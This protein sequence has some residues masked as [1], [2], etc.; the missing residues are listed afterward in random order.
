M[1]SIAIAQTSPKLLDTEA[2]FASALEQIE[3]I[4]A[5]IYLFPE[6]FLSGYA[7]STE[8]EVRECALPQENRFFNEFRTLSEE[9]GI[10]ISGGYAEVAEGGAIYNSGF[11]IGNGRLLLNYRKTHLYYREQQFFRPGDSGFSVVEYRGVRFGMMICFD[12]FFPEAARSLAIRGAQVIL[13]PAN[14]VLPYCQRA[15]FARS[16]ENGVF[17]ATA[18]RVGRETNALGDDL[19]F[20]GGSQVVTPKGEYVL[21]FSESESAVRSVEIDPSMADKKSLNQFNTIL[22]DRRPDL[23]VT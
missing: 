8:S 7:F 5:D 2:N 12:W 16:V 4:K 15:M 11:L 18:N 3:R 13:H 19:R 9:R 6:L 17:V 14:L 21:T 1:L 10:A 20:T 23:Y 22:E